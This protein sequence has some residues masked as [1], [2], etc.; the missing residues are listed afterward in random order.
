MDYERTGLVRADI[1]FNYNKITELLEGVMNEDMYH[2]QEQTRQQQDRMS[3]QAGRH[4][5]LE[6]VQIEQEIAETGQT[7]EGEFD[8]TPPS[9]GLW[10]RIKRLFGGK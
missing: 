5:T 7:P 2:R 3:A 10:A 4:T 1:R 9:P 8:T 6:T